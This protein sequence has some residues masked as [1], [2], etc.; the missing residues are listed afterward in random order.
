MLLAPVRQIQRTNA[1]WQQPGIGH[2]LARMASER[3]ALLRRSGT[4]SHGTA[5]RH[6]H[7][8]GGGTARASW[9][10]RARGA[11]RRR[12]RAPR[13]RSSHAAARRSAG[14]S[15][16]GTLRRA[17]V[18][19]SSA[20]ARASLLASARGREGGAFPELLLPHTARALPASMDGLVASPG[21]IG[22]QRRKR[23][24]D[25]A[26][27]GGGKAAKGGGPLLSTAPAPAAAPVKLPKQPAA[28]AKRASARGKQPTVAQA[29]C[30]AAA[31]AARGA[32]APSAEAEEAH[33]SAGA[34][35]G[36]PPPPHALPPR[37]TSGGGDAAPAGA[38]E[39]ATQPLAA[40]PA[41]AATRHSGSGSAAGATAALAQRAAA[42]AAAASAPVF[43][44]EVRI[45]SKRAAWHAHAAV[46]PRHC[47]C[48]RGG[49]HPSVCPCARAALTC[50]LRLCAPVS[51]RQRGRAGRRRRAVRGARARACL[52]SRTQRRACSIGRKPYPVFPA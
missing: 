21:K 3:V 39:P 18:C 38:E 42:A 44:T 25:E 6:R 17:L 36:L 31:P 45:L 9:Q 29:F 51:V 33:P 12:H 23:G 2:A 8:V 46:R 52:C 50:R 16:K 20:R 48:R 49:L 19:S 5:R 4:R 40:E 35:D 11:R 7:D 22:F 10:R 47:F 1:R 37:R 27:G 28:P 34:P 26:L 14:R 41:R 43:E 15:G 32:R 30:A 24:A 13:T